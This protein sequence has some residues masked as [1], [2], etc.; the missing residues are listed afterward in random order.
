[1]DKKFK[2]QLLETTASL[3]TAA[4]A[5][6]AALAW[7]STIQSLMKDIFGTASDTFGQLIY[8][9]IVTVVAVVATLIIART[10]AKLKGEDDKE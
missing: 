8:A 9:L 7:N 2:V 1:M 3:L 6:V 5:L 4:F 10:L